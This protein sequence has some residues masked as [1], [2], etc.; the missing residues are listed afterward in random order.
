MGGEEKSDGVE[1]FVAEK[2][3]DSVV[4]VERHSGL[5]NVLTVYAPHSW[6]LEEEKENFW[7]E[8]FHL[9]SC[10][11]QNE[12]VV[13]A[14]DM[15]ILFSTN[16]A[17]KGKGHYFLSAGSVLP[18]TRNS[19]ILYAICRM[20]TVSACM[21]RIVFVCKVV[22]DAFRLINP[23][24]MV[25]GQ[26]PRQATSNLGHLNKPSIQVRCIV[27]IISGCILS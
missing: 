2:W 23:N 13:L 24:M 22:I 20:Q 5:L 11:P 1:I 6:K 15:N 25:L 4:S 3:A 7:N 17:L 27:Y 19:L 12:M 14:G 18:A 8:L 21:I 9:V 26:E 10:I 16:Q